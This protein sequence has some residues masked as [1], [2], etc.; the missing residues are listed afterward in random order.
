MTKGIFITGTGTDIGKTFV[1][2]LIAK[3]LNESGLKTGYYKA[4]LSGAKRLNSELVLGDAKY[5]CEVSGLKYN[6]KKLVSYAYETAVSPHLAAKIE[7]NPIEI[8]TVKRDFES[9]KKDF[10]Y[11]TVE[12]SGGIVCPL[13]LDDK[14]VMLSDVIKCLNLDIIIVASA[15]LGTINTTVLTVEYAKQLEIN[16]KGII[17]NEYD[18]ENFLHI[19]NKKQVEYLTGVP[20]VACVSH[21]DE[22]LDIDIEELKNLY[23]G[24]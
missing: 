14:V 4:A 12:G 5:V 22:N 16:I 17:L 6:P 23:K 9:L 21:G 1:T 18:R 13:R 20:V 10:D 7:G 2:A 15:S 8:D 19:D 24:G 3:K 11:I